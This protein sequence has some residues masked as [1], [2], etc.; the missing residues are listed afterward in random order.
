MQVK[1]KTFP[2]AQFNR[3]FH[4]RIV[5]GAGLLSMLAF[6]A[7]AQSGQQPVQGN[8]DNPVLASVHDSAPDADVQSKA[9]EKP[10]KPQV[11]SAVDIQRRQLADESA[12]LLQLATELKRAVDNSDQHTLSIHIVRKADLIAKLAHGVKEEMKHAV[13]QR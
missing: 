4:R 2:S 13:A 10:V 5:A 8:A 7:L 11:D 1:C 3:P 12:R 6:T 9:L